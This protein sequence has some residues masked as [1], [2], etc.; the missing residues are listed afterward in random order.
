MGVPSSVW[1]HITSR[2][3][4]L[5]RL[6]GKAI[7][8]HR[9]VPIPLSPLLFEALQLHIRGDPHAA[10]QGGAGGPASAATTRLRVPRP[11]LGWTGPT[12]YRLPRSGLVVTPALAARVSRHA[13][14]VLEAFYPSLISVIDVASQRAAARALDPDA[15]PAQLFLTTPL[16]QAPVEDMC[17]EFRAPTTGVALGPTPD[18]SVTSANV[19]DYVVALARYV[20]CDGVAHAVACTVRGLGDVLEP[21][22][23]LMFTPGELA[24]LVCGQLEVAWTAKSLLDS[25]VWSHGYS[26]DSKEAGMLCKVLEGFDQAHRRQFL[27]F[28]TGCPTL[29]PGGLQGLARPLNVTRKG[30]PGETLRSEIDGSLPSA[31]TCFHQ[32]KLPPYSTPA[33]MAERLVYAMQASAGVIDMS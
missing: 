33:I 6:M 13:L 14:C 27:Q 31:S 8:E 9:L 22:R 32:V 28:L 3:T 1:D 2:C 20:A 18:D 19:D 5:G 24:D 15:H 30:T 12:S 16:G 7:Q 10:V 17:L 11:A 23:L 29:P 26:A 21:R 4:L 25:I